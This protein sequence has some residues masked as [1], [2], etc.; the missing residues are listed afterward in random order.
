MKQRRNNPEIKI[1]AVNE[2]LKGNVSQETIARRL[3]V[4][5][6]TVRLWIANY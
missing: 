2:Y 3:G 5:K 6:T 1:D 4:G